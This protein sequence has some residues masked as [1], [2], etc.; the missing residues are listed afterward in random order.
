[1]TGSS[2]LY[3]TRRE[4]PTLLVRAYERLARAT[5]PNVRIHANTTRRLSFSSADIAYAAGARPANN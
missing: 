1:M 5:E 3:G 2:T 4:I